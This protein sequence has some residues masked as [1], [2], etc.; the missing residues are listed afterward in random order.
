MQFQGDGPVTLARVTAEGL[1]V[2]VQ[3]ATE[4]ADCVEGTL[5]AVYYDTSDEEACTCRDDGTDLEWVK[6]T[7]P[8]HS[9]HCSI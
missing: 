1:S 3:A 8:T 4:P 9:G 7:D 2:P 6:A 5:G